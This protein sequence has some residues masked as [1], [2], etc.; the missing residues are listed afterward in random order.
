ML[1]IVA[2][3]L[4]LTGLGLLASSANYPG[5][6][7]VTFLNNYLAENASPTDVS[8]RPKQVHVG[9]EAKMS[10]ASN[11]V[12]L[13][14]A[15]A[16]RVKDDKAWYLSRSSWTPPPVQFDRSED[17]AYS[18]LDRLVSGGRFDYALVDATESQDEVKGGD[19]EVLYQATAFDGF[20][21]R[22]VAAGRWREFARKAVKVKVVKLR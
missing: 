6:S 13:D 22:A 2:V 11:F 18:T 20:D 10:G 16:T 19:V 15:H 1:T 4:L 21:S 14:S 17:L 3:N 8:G 9:I 5:Y 12:L 7:A